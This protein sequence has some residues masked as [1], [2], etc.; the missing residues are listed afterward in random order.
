VVLTKDSKSVQGTP[1]EFS[2]AG[3]FQ[4]ADGGREVFNFNVGWRFHKGPTKDAE[5][6]GFDDS[7]WEVVNTPHGL[8]ILP[9]AASGSINYQGEAWYRKHFVVP[10]SMAGR[11]VFLHFEAVMG[12]SKVWVNGKLV[13]EH[14]GGYLPIVIDVTVVVTV[15]K[16]NI[17]A[18]LTDNS[19]DSTYPPGKPQEA[20][21]FCYFGGIY[22]DVWL[23][24]TAPVSITD[25]TFSG[26]V[27]GGGVFVHYENLTKD[28][29]DVVVSTEVANRS[30][31]RQTLEVV[32]TL[33][34]AAGNSVG[35]SVAPIEI[36]AG[37]SSS[38]TQTIPVNKPHLWHPNDPYL[39]RTG[40]RKTNWGQSSS[41]IC[42]YRQCG[43][44]F[45]ALARCQKIARCRYADYPLVAL[46]AGSRV[47][48]CLR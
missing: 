11:R 43:S 47:H 40:W 41:G 14:F 22:R 19:N 2:T 21:D 31:S 20:M 44:E 38:V 33:Y 17:V 39:H 12:K 48:G 5:A 10:E 25:P 29:A 30:N 15:G 45:A 18:V 27:A 16:Q 36:E 42:L 35:E 23:Y 6:V 24:S 4:I 26:T 46:S 1:H 13:K 37:K 7:A 32:S 28:H 3:F 34:D 9:D 8:E